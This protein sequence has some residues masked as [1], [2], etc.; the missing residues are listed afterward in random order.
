MINFTRLLGSLYLFLSFNQYSI[1]LSVVFLLIGRSSL[2]TRDTSF[3]LFTTFPLKQKDLSDPYIY[4]K[5]Y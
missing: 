3:Y 4:K 5:F 2:Y 1:S